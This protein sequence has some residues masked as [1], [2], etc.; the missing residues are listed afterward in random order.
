MTP[1]G[2]LAVGQLVHR[3]LPISPPTS[4]RALWTACAVGSLA[5]DLDFVF[6]PFSW[7]NELHRTG[8]HSL[9]F[10]LGLAL[11]CA[12][13]LDWRR[14]AICGLAHLAAD[15]LVD[16]NP[17]NGTGVAWLWPLSRE[18][19]GMGWS[20]TVVT[21]PP[22]TEPL[23]WEAVRA[24]LLNAIAVEVPLLVGAVWLAGR[25]TRTGNRTR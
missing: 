5:P 12:R 7:F 2:H 24:A 15:T 18:V 11:L 16:A 25:R 22:W 8:S 21:A 23:G 19:Y 13:W 20:L 1:L 6:L 14:M 10:V 17:D 3:A 9:V 4:E